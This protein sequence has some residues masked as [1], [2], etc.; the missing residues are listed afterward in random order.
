MV[1]EGG[2]RRSEY[3]WLGEDKSVD[4]VSTGGWGRVAV[5]VVSTGGGGRIDQ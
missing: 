1:G 4:T 2:S 3:W 5:Y